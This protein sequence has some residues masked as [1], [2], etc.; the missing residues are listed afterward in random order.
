[1][2]TLLIRRFF[3]TIPTLLLVYTLT[4]FIMHNTPGGPWDD[5]A[6]A[7]HPQVQENI[8]RAYN[9]DKPLWY[10]YSSYLWDI[11]SRGDFGPSY[12]SGGRSVMAIIRDFF[13]TSARIG[14]GAIVL[15]MS[16]G[17]VLGVV[18]AIKEG[19]FFDHLATFISVLGVSVPS[20]V[21]AILLIVL[22]GVSLGW[23]SLGVWGGVLSGRG[24][25]A[26]FALSLHPMAMIARYSRSSM[27]DVM[28][29]DYIRTARAKGLFEKKVVFK[30]ALRNAIIP[31]ATI[32]GLSFARVV[33]GSFIV[34]TITM[35]PGIGRYFVQSIFGRDYPVIMGLTILYALIIITANLLVDIMYGLI[36]PRIRYS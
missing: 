33:V 36:D 27:I 31:V 5:A 9:L 23:V 16:F 34:E 2:T 21:I 7:L 8:R 28:H 11:V 24:L 3:W 29:K 13:P 12:G 22:F 25:L 30:H 26:V 35:V 17:I 6:R 32:S 15:A 20:F 1:M 19:S 18:G 10:Q 4:F 14:L